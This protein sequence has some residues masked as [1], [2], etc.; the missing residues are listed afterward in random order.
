M[1]RSV[2]VAALVVLCT[3]PSLASAESPHDIVWSNTTAVRLNPLGLVVATDVEYRFRLYESESLALKNNFVGVG[4]Q[5]IIS[6]AWFRGGPFLSIQPAS[7]ANF[8]VGYEPVTYF[9]GFDQVLSFP[10]ANSEYDDDTLEA[11]GE[12]G[13]NAATS[14]SVLYVAAL[15]QA[16]VGP[17]AVRNNLRFSKF[18][19]DL[20]D[21][22]TVYYEQTWDILVPGDGWIFTND[23]DVLFL[24]D[25]GLVAGVRY[26]VTNALYDDFPNSEDNENGPI[27][28]LGPLI[29]YGVYSN[30]G[31]SVD[32]FSVFTLVNWH[33]SHRYRTGEKV[34]Q[35]VPYFALGI[36]T[37]GD[38]L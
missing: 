34:S 11:L 1:K 35:A 24:T 14:G 23:A 12:A 6:P 27:H 9:G 15:L 4:V 36:K 3:L 13:E 31:G 10:D 18:N 16:K 30:P 20:P 29:S 17:V 2:F 37:T 25:F 32:S 38:L 33:L 5:P 21:G 19:V 26:N 28:R 8:R 22:D 7:V